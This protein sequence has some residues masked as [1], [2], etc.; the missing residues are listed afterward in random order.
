MLEVKCGIEPL[1][2]GELNA[3][4]S[5]KCS[6]LAAPHQKCYLMI[7]RSPRD[8]RSEPSAVLSLIA[9]RKHVRL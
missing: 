9:F 1:R 4:A 3:R 7:Q 5:C 8:K 2:Q 6:T